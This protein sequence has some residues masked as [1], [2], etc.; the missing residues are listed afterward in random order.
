MR[1]INPKRLAPGSTS[2]R[3]CLDTEAYYEACIIRA[4]GRHIL[5]PPVSLRGEG[6]HA[7]FDEEKNWNEAQGHRPATVAGRDVG[8]PA[9]GVSQEL[10]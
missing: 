9:S 4:E 8:N 2:A 3:V 1:K 10:Q 5:H 7:T 6:S